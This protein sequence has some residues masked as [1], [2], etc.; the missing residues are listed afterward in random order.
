M[1]RDQSVGSLSV[2]VKAN[3]K[4]FTQ[5]M[6][7]AKRDAR[8]FRKEAED[9]ARGAGR[10][11]DGFSAGFGKNTQGIKF[12]AGQAAHGLLQFTEASSAAGKA[13]SGLQ[14][15]MGGLFTGGLVGAG[16]AGVSTVFNLLSEGSRKAKEEA[17]RAAEEKRAKDKQEAERGVEDARRANEQLLQVGEHRRQEEERR[18]LDSLERRA[19]ARGDTF[20]RALQEELRETPRR[21]A[22][23]QQELQTE[24]AALGALQKAREAA[25]GEDARNL[26]QAIRLRQQNVQLLQQELKALGARPDEAKR[27]AHLREVVRLEEERL[28]RQKEA[29]AAIA[30]EQKA[31]TDQLVQLREALARQTEL[32][33]M[34]EQE[35]KYAQAIPGLRELEAAGLKDLVKL[36]KDLVDYEEARA[37]HVKDAAAAKAKAEAGTKLNADLKDRE[38]LAGALNEADRERIR[39]QQE[40]DRLVASGADKAQAQRTL[41]AEAAQAKKGQKDATEGVVQGLKD[42]L[43]LLKAASEEERKRLERAQQLRDLLKQGGAEAV[44]AQQELNKLLDEAEAKKKKAADQATGMKNAGRAGAAGS[45]LDTLD[46]DGNLVE[47]SDTPLADARKARKDA[48]RHQKRRRAAIG[49]GMGRSIHDGRMSGLGG[50]RSGRQGLGGFSSWYGGGGDMGVHGGEPDGGEV[51]PGWKGDKP[52]GGAPG[53]A[54]PKPPTYAPAITPSAEAGAPGNQGLS[55]G[56][57]SLEEAEK[58]NAE[59]QKATAESMKGAATKAGEAAGSAKE[60]AEGAGKLVE[61]AEQLATENKGLA[62]ALGTS[63]QQTVKTMEAARDAVKKAQ[64]DLKALT[65]RLATIEKTMSGSPG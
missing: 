25:S 30:A 60:A 42:Q 53:A 24:Q 33:N 44:K 35:R 51:G 45:G 48:V 26:D 2:S 62:D 8:G 31:R 13:A 57:K 46:K 64:E 29:H 61:G 41:D 21:T 43:E 27:E 23:R 39:Q 1:A 32:A 28:A 19:K 50:I 34:T 38:N 17:A 12:G 49:R 7:Q 55:E 36:A 16:I 11:W 5:G 54:G 9:A 18:E 15:V 6:N 40:L 10:T 37:K 59:A 63:G 58:V 4:G 65:D 56:V 47:G 22:A 3:A 14:Q 52:G 20:D